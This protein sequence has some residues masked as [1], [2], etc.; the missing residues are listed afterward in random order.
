MEATHR[1]IRWGRHYELGIE[2]LD[3]QHEGMTTLLNLL[4]AQWLDNGPRKE[5]EATLKKL[6]RAVREHFRTEE[7]F[8]AKHQYDRLASHRIEHK[9]FAAE[10]AAFERAFRQGD[11]SLDEAQLRSLA[12][13]LRNHLVVSDRPMS[14]AIRLRGD[15]H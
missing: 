5:L 12:N 11:A 2:T 13:W 7:R 3:E 14:D 1:L 6:L 15:V 9:T 4:Y 10:V 8:M